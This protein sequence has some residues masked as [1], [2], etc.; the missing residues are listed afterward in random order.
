M[1][2][3]PKK[4]TRK[5]GKKAARKRAAKTPKKGTAKKRGGK[6]ARRKSAAKAPK[7]AARRR[8]ASAMLRPQ[9]Q[10]ASRVARVR[11]TARRPAARAAV[12]VRRKRGAVEFGRELAAL[13]TAHAAT[14]NARADPGIVDIDWKVFYDEVAHELV[15]HYAVK[16]LDPDGVLLQVMVK[17]EN[18][19]LFPPED[20][21]RVSSILEFPADQKVRAVRGALVDAKWR[22]DNIGDPYLATCWGFVEVRGETKRFGPFRTSY[23]FPPSP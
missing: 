11:A 13:F 15:I 2:T 17:N 14:G 21:P 1:T 7:L 4:K 22:K 6:A 12:A 18:T 10:I 23:A 8:L 9:S 16:I 20:Q 3:R 19:R 5:P